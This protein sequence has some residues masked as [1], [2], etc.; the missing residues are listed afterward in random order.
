MGETP[1]LMD[2]LKFN[3]QVNSFNIVPQTFLSE[4]ICQTLSRRPRAS[5]GITLHNKV[6]QGRSQAILIEMSNPLGLRAEDGANA[7]K[8]ETLSE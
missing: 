4:G 1:V 7:L 6:S 5:P 8:G 3:Y 2:G